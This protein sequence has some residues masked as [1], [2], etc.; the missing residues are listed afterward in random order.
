MVAWWWVIPGFVAVVGLAFALSGVGWMFRGRPFKGGRGVIGGGAFLSVA[1]IVGLLGLNIQTYHTLSW[2]QPIATI[3]IHK[4]GDQHFQVVVTEVPTADN[5]NPDPPHTYDMHGDQWRM[6]ARVLVW[7]PWAR[8]LGLTAQYRL[9]RFS[10]RYISTEQELNAERSVYPIRPVRSSG[11]DLWPVAR[12]YMQ[13]LPLV[14]TR[15][16]SGTFQP[17]VDG[18]TYEVRINQNGLS[19]RPTNEVA[20]EAT[21]SGWD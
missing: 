10:G 7:K 11:I 4:V 12:E 6:E 1:A 19:S 5:P 18:A 16:G 3:Q 20:S 14:E 17:M 8:V 13:Y 15:H 21:A 2:D 9:D